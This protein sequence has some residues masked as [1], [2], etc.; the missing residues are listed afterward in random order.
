MQFGWYFCVVIKCTYLFPPVLDDYMSDISRFGYIYKFDYFGNIFII[1]VSARSLL[2]FSYRYIWWAKATAFAFFC[3]AYSA[4]F[5][6]E[7]EN[8]ITC[9]GSGSIE[10]RHWKGPKKGNVKMWLFGILGSTQ[11]RSRR[12]AITRP[13]SEYRILF[14]IEI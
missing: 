14:V 6:T 3:F 4:L 7:N 2:Y 1:L 11:N 5:K 13:T 9:R 8:A 10:F 12:N